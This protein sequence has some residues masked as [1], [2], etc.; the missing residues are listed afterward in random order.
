MLRE[1][2][3]SRS[4]H[5]LGQFKFS[6]RNKWMYLDVD[7][8]GVTRFPNLSTLGMNQGPF[9][10]EAVTRCAVF[11]HCIGFEDLIDDPSKA[12]SRGGRLMFQVWIAAPVSPQDD[13]FI[14]PKDGLDVRN[15]PIFR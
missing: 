8:Y 2:R 9:A 6:Q 7:L 4:H 5:L 12:N 11:I 10:L 1:P 15:E 3:L 14:C 13:S